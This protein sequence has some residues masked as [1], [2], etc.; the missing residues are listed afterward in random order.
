MTDVVAIRSRR[1]EKTGWSEQVAWLRDRLGS[2]LRDLSDRQT[3]AL[4][5]GLRRTWG[6]QPHAAGEGDREA[7]SRRIRLLGQLIAGLAAADPETLRADRAGYGSTVLAR[8]LHTGEETFHTLVG[9]D[10][11]DVDA[12][13]V[14]LASPLGQAL[15]GCRAGDEVLVEAP[16]GTRRLRVVSVHTLAQ[17]VGMADPAAPGAA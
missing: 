12:N 5:D 14:S 1:A 4:A 3:S 13:Q 17:S 10:L 2:E 16:R 11:I 6:G 9:G 7:V 8:D 15:L